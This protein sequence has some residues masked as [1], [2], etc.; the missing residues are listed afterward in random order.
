MEESTYPSPIPKRSTFQFPWSAEQANSQVQPVENSENQDYQPDPIVPPEDQS[1]DD[2]ENRATAWKSFSKDGNAGNVTMRLLRDSWSLFKDLRLEHWVEHVLGMPSAAISLF[3]SYHHRLGFSLFCFLCQAPEELEKYH[4]VAKKVQPTDRFLYDT[5]THA[6]KSFENNQI[7][8][9]LSLDASLITSPLKAILSQPDKN[10]LRR[11]VVLGNRYKRYRRCSGLA[12]GREFQ[13]NTAFLE[14]LR[15]KAVPGIAWEISRDTFDDFRKI[16]LH[17]IRDYDL[18]IRRLALRWDNLY[19]DVDDVAAT[20]EF[21]G[22]LMG[23]FT[24]YEISFRFL[25]F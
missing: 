4:G 12:Q 13:T 10:I 23:S 3:E 2:N 11:L 22:T 16:S 21:D 5:I 9:P 14:I 8:S 18:H 19:Y 25:L 24:I 6:V 1:G 20:G 7:Y 17:S 15:E